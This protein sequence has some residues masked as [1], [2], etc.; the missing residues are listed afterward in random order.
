MKKCRNAAAKFLL[1]LGELDSAG[2]APAPAQQLTFDDHRIA[3]RFRS[4][5]GL[6]RAGG[7]DPP[8]GWDTHA[9]EQ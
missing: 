5:D 8:G 2:L 3:Y 7:H 6:F 1:V 9:P 4:I